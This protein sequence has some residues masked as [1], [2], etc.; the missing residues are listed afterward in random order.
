MSPPQ[1]IELNA[2]KKGKEGQSVDKGKRSR[3]SCVL[4]SGSK[5]NLRPQEL[6]CAENPQLIFNWFQSCVPLLAFCPSI[7]AVVPVSWLA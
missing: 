2:G 6:A 3:N 4:L 7:P 5:P 1:K